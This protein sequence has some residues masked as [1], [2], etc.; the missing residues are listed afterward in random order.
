MKT[1]ATRRQILQTGASALALPLV[2]PAIRSSAADKPKKR[3]KVAVIYTVFRYRSHTH[4]IL[5]NFLQPYLFNGKRTD[6][7]VDV[8]SFYVDQSPE[9]DMSRDV[10]RQFKIP[11]YKTIREALCLGGGSLAVDAVRLK[12]GPLMV[13]RENGWA[14]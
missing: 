6:Q 8:V 5:E 11:I 7:G 9:S 3:P 4:V 14:G 1:L 2:L 10:S 13:F 12:Y